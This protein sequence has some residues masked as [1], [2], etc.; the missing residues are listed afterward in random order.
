MTGSKV[1]RVEWRCPVCDR[2]YRIP[3]DSTLPQACPQCRDQ[4][5]DSSGAKE[6]VFEDT[7]LIDGPQHAGTIGGQRSDSGLPVELEAEITRRERREIMRHLENISRTMTFFRRL[8]WSLAACLLLNAIV[9]GGVIYYSVQ[10]MGALGQ[11]FSGAVSE[12]RP[13]S[14]VG[15]QPDLQQLEQSVRSLMNEIQQR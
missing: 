12:E 7:A 9:M 5:N 1:Q 3:A 13:A 14:G 6:I 11:M 4:T 2:R 15:P 8:A 10:Q